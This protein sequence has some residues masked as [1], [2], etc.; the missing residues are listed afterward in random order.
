MSMKL[1]QEEYENACK[2][3]PPFN[4]AHEGYAI[5]KEEV[6]ELW[7]LVKVK[8]KNHDLASMRDEAVQI[9]AMALR[10]ITDVCD[11]EVK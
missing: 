9:A 7:T 4:S 5:L 1:I 10:F 6:D 8:Q 11:K 2:H 3:Y